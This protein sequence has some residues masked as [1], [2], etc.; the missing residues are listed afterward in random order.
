MNHGWTALIFSPSSC[1]S[2]SPWCILK[3]CISHWSRYTSVSCASPQDR[4]SLSECMQVGV[5]IQGWRTAQCESLSLSKFF[6][7]AIAPQRCWITYRLKTRIAIVFSPV[8]NNLQVYHYIFC[9]SWEIKKK[10]LNKYSLTVFPVQNHISKQLTFTT[11][12]QNSIE[13]IIAALDNRFY[14]PSRYFKFISSSWQIS[15]EHNS[16]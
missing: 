14:R 4:I 1:T 5:G 2:R 15:N 6:T 3:R 10:I 12:A 16:L 11:T 8:W 13:Y 7:N 9:G